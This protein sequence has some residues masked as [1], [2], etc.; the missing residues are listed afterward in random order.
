MDRAEEEE[1]EDSPA[2][3][4]AMAAIA[5]R[6]AGWEENKANT[7]G[8][9]QAFEAGNALA[10]FGYSQRNVQVVVWM[11]GD[12]P[13]CERLNGTRQR[14]GAPFVSEGDTVEATDGATAALAVSRTIRHGPLHGGCDCTV[15]AG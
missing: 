9:D 10:L 7:T 5:D 13:L 14:I 15:M 4:L 11:G 12:C 8:Q 6:L 1:S 3:G 2:V